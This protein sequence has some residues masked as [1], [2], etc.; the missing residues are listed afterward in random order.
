VV[1]VNVNDIPL[2]K[3]IAY[4]ALLPDTSPKSHRIIIVFV[5]EAE[6]RYFYVT[7][8]MDTAKKILRNDIGAFVEIYRNEWAQTLT[9]DISCIQCDKGHLG[10]IDIEKFREMYE[11]DEIELVGDVPEVIKQKIKTAV[12][13]SI[14]YNFVEQSQ[15]INP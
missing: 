9:E 5:T 1:K 2:R 11:N 4:K 12:E 14:T 13:N 15:L 7:S 3:R 8:K 6:I 10:C